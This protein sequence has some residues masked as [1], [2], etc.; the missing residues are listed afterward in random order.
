MT[1]DAALNQFFNGF[2]IPAFPETAVPDDQ[3]MPY[4]TYSFAISLFD[5]IPVN[6]TAYV[7][8]KTESEAVPTAKAMEI[9]EAI[10]RDGCT[11]PIDG[12]YIWLYMG[13]PA[14]RPVP[15]EDNSVKR[16]ALNITAEYFR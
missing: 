2:D 8:Y 3:M 5:D 9:M 11:V 14:L 1:A 4:I 15:D 16:R 12:G 10:G 7:W 13:S 6:M